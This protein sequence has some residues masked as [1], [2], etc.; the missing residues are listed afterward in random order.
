MQ[1]FR[2]E[3]S[4]RSDKLFGHA[5]DLAA[6]IATV[7]AAITTISAIGFHLAA[8]CC[9]DAQDYHRKNPTKTTG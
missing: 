2:T 5:K 4:D 3:S 7:Y 8:A 1:L 9:T 6:T